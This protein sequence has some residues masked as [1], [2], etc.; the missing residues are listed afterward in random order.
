M[1]RPRKTRRVCSLPNVNKFGPINPINTNED[2]IIMTVEQ[3]EAIRLIDLEGLTQQE[4]SE[5][6][7]VGRS[8]LQR[9]YEVAREKLADA[10][11]NGKTL[12]IQGGHYKICDEFEEMEQCRYGLCQR[13]RRGQGRK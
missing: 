6:M 9:I 8:T 3:F 12:K 5:L 1:A 7:G 11:V 13:N 10:L 4:S 2:C